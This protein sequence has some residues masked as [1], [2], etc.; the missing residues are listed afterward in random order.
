MWQ[1]PLSYYAT[2]GARAFGILGQIAEDHDEFPG[3]TMAEYATL[4]CGRVIEPKT[5]V[6]G[7]HS[8]GK[9]DGESEVQLMLVLAILYNE[10]MPNQC[11]VWGMWATDVDGETSH[12][13]LWYN[14]P[15]IYRSNPI[16]RSTVEGM[17]DEEK[18]LGLNWPGKIALRHIDPSVKVVAR[19]STELT[20]DLD[21]V[22]LSAVAR[23]LPYGRGKNTYVLFEPLPDD[24]TFNIDAIV[25][26]IS[27]PDW[28]VLPTARRG[29][30]GVVPFEPSFK[31]VKADLFMAA[32]IGYRIG[33]TPGLLSHGAYFLTPTTLRRKLGIFTGTVDAETVE[34]F[35]V[36][37]FGWTPLDEIPH[38]MT[39]EVATVRK[40]NLREPVVF[41]SGAAMRLARLDV[42]AGL[43]VSL[44]HML[45]ADGQA[46]AIAEP[47]TDREVRARTPRARTAAPYPPDPASPRTGVRGAQAHAHE[48]QPGC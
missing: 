1:R 46:L 5:F 26:M 13:A 42:G 44:T 22:A 10:D 16:S 40:Q 6:H 38:G 4:P 14:L 24:D 8:N 39:T 23:S 15:G 45:Y 27:M 30:S 32:G 36:E 47:A 31:P 33:A 48:P 3:L 41:A 21:A 9:W 29:P 43:T 17:H 7:E 20:K 37:Q 25:A 11:I 12:L 2:P 28:L 18:M 19:W 35:V 34:L